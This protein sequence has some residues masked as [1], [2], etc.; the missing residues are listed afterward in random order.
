MKLFEFLSIWMNWMHD[1][2]LMH[3]ILTCM[4]FLFYYSK[5]LIWMYENFRFCLFK[6]MKI[7]ICNFVPLFK[8][9]IFYAIIGFIGI[10][11]WIWKRYSQTLM[12]DTTIVNVIDS[13]IL[14]H[15]CQ[16][17]W[18]NNKKKY[19][20]DMLMSATLFWIFHTLWELIMNAT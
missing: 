2:M 18:K 6:C 8:S 10:Q 16:N 1:S 13:N 20:K 9:N 5:M 12:P 7:L 11:I 19:G 17:G 3:E 4:R 14:M 15:M